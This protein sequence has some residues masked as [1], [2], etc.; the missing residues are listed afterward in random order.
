MKKQIII[1]SLLVI[2]SIFISSCLAGPN[3]EAF[4]PDNGGQI[5]GFLMGLWH[6]CIAPVTFVIS[7]FSDNIHMYEIHNNGGWYDFGF[8][9]GAG[10]IF[11]GGGKASRRRRRR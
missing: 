11:G 3:T 9:I 4:L 2:A 6:G 1:L 7:L 5:D 8:V 10:I